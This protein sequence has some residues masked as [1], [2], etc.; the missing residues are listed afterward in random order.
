MLTQYGW[1]SLSQRSDAKSPGAEAPGLLFVSGRHAT[2][3]GFRFFSME[4]VATDDVFE[5]DRGA[6]PV[7]IRNPGPEKSYE[8]PDNF[9]AP[10]LLHV[11]PVVTGASV[12]ALFVSRV[13]K[14][15]VSGSRRLYCRKAGSGLSQCLPSFPPEPWCLVGHQGFLGA[16]S[17]LGLRHCILNHA[18][19]HR[20]YRTADAATDQLAYDNFPIDCGP[21]AAASAG[22]SAPRICP[23][24]TPPRAPVWYSRLY[25]N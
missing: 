12:G 14:I 2:G 24:P 16:L 18:C 10:G 1:F 7:A 21:A 23:P 5:A 17:R 8:A 15:T 22:T 20:E 4:P 9:P 19:D 13:A 3:S 11:S 25:P 6:S